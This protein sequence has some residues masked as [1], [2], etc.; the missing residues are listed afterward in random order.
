MIYHKMWEMLCQ[1][2][3]ITTS[4]RRILPVHGTSLTFNSHISN[5]FLFEIMFNLKGIKRVF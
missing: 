3:C 5:T 1:K 2:N 4:V